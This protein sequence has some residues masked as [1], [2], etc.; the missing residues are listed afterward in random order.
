MMLDSIDKNK[1]SLIPN[2]K[3]RELYWG[4]VY[5]VGDRVMVIVES[6]RS[7]NELKS[8]RHFAI[9]QVF[10]YPVVGRKSAYTCAEVNVKFFCHYLHFTLIAQSL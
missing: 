3:T 6:L 5:C 8:K 4:H 7:K 2:I 9:V 10:V 1:C